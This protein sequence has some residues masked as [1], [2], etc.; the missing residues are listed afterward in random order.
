M[1][2]KYGLLSC[3]KKYSENEF[4]AAQ[5]FLKDQVINSFRNAPRE[6]IMYDRRIGKKDEFTNYFFKVLSEIEDGMMNKRLPKKK[7]N[8]KRSANKL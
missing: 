8:S 6:K 5:S 4:L 1:L 7:R 3:F 2:K